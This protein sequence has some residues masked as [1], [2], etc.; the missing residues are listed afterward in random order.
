MICHPGT[1]TYTFD[2][3]ARASGLKVSS[4]DLCTAAGNFTFRD[5]LVVEWQ[6]AGGG[7]CHR[8]STA[9]G[10]SSGSFSWEHRVRSQFLQCRDTMQSSRRA[11]SP[12]QP[13]AY[14]SPA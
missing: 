3:L 2:I 10:S 1:Y 14:A 7:F 11:S 9:I 8:G 6:G 12:E 5:A 13:A 4:K